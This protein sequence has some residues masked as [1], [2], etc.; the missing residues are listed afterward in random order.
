MEN[1]ISAILE[2]EYK[3]LVE[4]LSKKFNIEKKCLLKSFKNY[5]SKTQIKKP[6]V[7]KPKEK[8]K[9]EKKIKVIKPEKPKK[10]VKKKKSLPSVLSSIIEIKK[11]EEI[12]LNSEYNFYEHS[13]TNFIFDVIEKQVIGKHVGNGIVEDLEV[14]DIEMCKQY[15]FLYIVPENLEK[16]IKINVLETSLEEQIKK[17]KFTD[18]SDCEEEF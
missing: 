3:L 14:K 12:C 15:K 2:A 11:V 18:S 8:L 5:F 13:P 7:K 6:P 9:V 10:T 4:N 17:F 1:K 16:K